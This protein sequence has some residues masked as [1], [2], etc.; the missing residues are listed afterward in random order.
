MTRRP[1]GRAHSL[2][3]LSQARTRRT[4]ERSVAGLAPRRDVVPLWTRRIRI[5]GATSIDLGRDLDPRTSRRHPDRFVSDAGERHDRRPLRSRS[6]PTRVTTSL[7]AGSDRRHGT[8]SRP[9]ASDAT[10]PTNVTTFSCI[11]HHVPARTSQRAPTSTTTDP[12]ERHDAPARRSRPAPTNVT[13]SPHFDREP[14]DPPWR[15]P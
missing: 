5:D 9:P 8:T 10:G 1:R 12:G 4:F 14:V 13:T 11:D 7:P 6:N 15:R 3:S 2:S